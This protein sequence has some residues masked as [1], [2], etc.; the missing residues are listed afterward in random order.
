MAGDD[1]ASLQRLEGIAGGS[2]AITIRRI[3]G[4]WWD[5]FKDDGGAVLADVGRLD[6]GAIVLTSIC[7]LNGEGD[8]ADCDDRVG[9]PVGAD[10]PQDEG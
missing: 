5:F 3:G 7:A 2:D 9:D 4:E 8:A 1:A 10:I 6:P